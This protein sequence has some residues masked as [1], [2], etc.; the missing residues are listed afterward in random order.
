M[1]INKVFTLNQNRFSFGP[2][3]ARP[4]DGVGIP[5]VT[6]IRLDSDKDNRGDLKNK[7]YGPL[8]ANNYGISGSFCWKFPRKRAGTA[9]EQ[10]YLVDIGDK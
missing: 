4:N 3:Y 7:L 6:N 8:K 10:W 1:Q 2:E 5:L 9:Y